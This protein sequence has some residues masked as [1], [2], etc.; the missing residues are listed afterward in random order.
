MR[1]DRS[2]AECRKKE[3]VERRTSSVCPGANFKQQVASS[4]VIVN[5]D[6]RRVANSQWKILRVIDPS[7]SCNFIYYTPFIIDDGSDVRYMLSIRK[8]RL[9]PWPSLINERSIK[10]HN[11]IIRDKINMQRAI[12]D[13]DLDSHLTLLATLR[14]FLGSH[15]SS[16]WMEY[17]FNV[18][19]FF[20]CIYVIY[21]RP[22]A[23]D[24]R[25]T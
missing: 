24:P 10:K 11:Y 7:V 1:S 23:R 13:H 12:D 15:L 2:I 20:D 9:L 17:E 19:C 14:A 5:E 16:W 25:D 18:D 3:S 22:H 8:Q 6:S 4:R 21:C